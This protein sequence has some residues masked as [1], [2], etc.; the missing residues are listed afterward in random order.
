MV[1]PVTLGE[2]IWAPGPQVGLLVISLRIYYLLKYV[3]MQ[4]ARAPTSW[5]ASTLSAYLRD[6]PL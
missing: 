1:K 5:L 6:R 2:R 3:I 4:S